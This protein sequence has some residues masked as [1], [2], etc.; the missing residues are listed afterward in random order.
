MIAFLP[1]KYLVRLLG[2]KF[3][4]AF[5]IALVLALIYFITLTKSI[6]TIVLALTLTYLFM[7]LTLILSSQ[8]NQ[9]NR[10]INN[11]DP[12][13]FDY[14]TLKF[15]DLLS[16]NTILPLLLSF[17]E[18]TRINDQQKDQLK[19]VGH[20]A[21]QVIETAQS[22]SKNVKLQFDATSSTASAILEMNQSICEVSNKIS[23][24]HLSAK[25]AN[26]I[27]QNG[28]DQITSLAE[29]ITEVSNVTIETQQGMHALDQLAQ[30]VTLITE[31]IQNISSQINLLALNASIEAAR[32]GS[33]G[34]GF[35]VV[36]EEVRNLAESTHSSSD[37]IANKINMVLSK[38]N[39]TVKRMKLVVDKTNTCNEKAF[40]VNT[41]L[42][43]IALATDS[44]QQ[45]TEI[46]SVIAEQQALA[47]QE[48]S[49]HIEQ[50]VHSSEANA[51]TAQQAELVAD[52]LRKL[53]S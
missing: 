39:E 41:I 40:N 15:D 46:V 52:H 12:D 27:A 37:H 53:T 25:Q 22:V 5:F 3:T 6:T 51:N 49:E 36:A 7:G 45:E 13:N 18:L 23:A 20:S 32:A 4:I 47:T 44:V 29:S 28:Q 26:N 24:T 2:L 10:I 35:A 8:L 1:I 14:R 21:T 19:E 34:R 31:S 17:R 50:V 30:E 48:I 9:F 33:Y 43:D 11:F 42:N 38:S 16:K